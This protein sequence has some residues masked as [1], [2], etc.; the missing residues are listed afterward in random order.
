[1]LAAALVIAHD[2]GV[3]SALLTCD[4]DN[5][6]SRRV[7]ERNGGMLEDERDGKLR[8]WVPTSTGG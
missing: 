3:E 7:I 4:D 2:L 5:V 1:M 8:Y 6:A